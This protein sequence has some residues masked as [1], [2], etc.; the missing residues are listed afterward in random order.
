MNGFIPALV[1]VMLAEMGP[2]AM[3]YAAARRHQAGLWLIAV[4]VLLAGAAGALTK[5]MMN[6]R[7]A[8]LMIAIALLFAAVGQLQRIAPAKGTF[9]TLTAF[10]RG[11]VPILVFALATR[12]GPLSACFGALGGM[13]GAAVTTRALQAG[14]VPMKPIRWA[15]AAL[16][17]IVAAFLAVTALRLV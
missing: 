9:R 7:A 11:G 14:G 5:S 2:R 15:A 8:T 17:A 3:L 16:L 4:L 13:L 1:A 12:F 6:V 10:W